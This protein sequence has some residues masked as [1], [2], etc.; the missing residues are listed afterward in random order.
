[1]NV[2]VTVKY[3]IGALCF[4]LVILIAVVVTRHGILSIIS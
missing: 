3:Y 2:T 4:R 1:M